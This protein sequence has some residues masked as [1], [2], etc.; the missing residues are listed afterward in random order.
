M[1]GRK[2]T[3]RGQA[4]EVNEIQIRIV[5]FLNTTDIGAKTTHCLLSTNPLNNGMEWE[6]QQQFRTPM[7]CKRKRKRQYT[8][9]HYTTLHY[10]TLHYT[11]V[12]CHNHT[13]KLCPAWPSYWLIAT[14][15]VT[16]LKQFCTSCVFERAGLRQHS[17]NG[18]EFVRH[19][20]HRQQRVHG[21]RPSLVCG[22]VGN[23]SRFGLVG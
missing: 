19:C 5:L 8:T 23:T 17:V 12:W 9:L 6:P 18:L 20:H 7:R 11:T 2:S 15:Y 3:I 10:T 22:I 1:G 16:H 4:R 13:N 21:C 14:E